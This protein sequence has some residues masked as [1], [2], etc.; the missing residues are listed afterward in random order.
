MYCDPV[1][2]TRFQSTPSG[3]KAT[4]S[5]NAACA[6]GLVSIHAFRGEGDLLLHRCIHPRQIVSIHAFRGEGDTRATAAVARTQEVSIHAFRGEGDECHCC[7]RIDRGDV[8]IHAFRGEGDRRVVRAVAGR[9]CFNP[10]LPGGR[11]RC[12]R[13]SVN[14]LDCFNPRL[15]GGRRRR[16]LRCFEE[17][18]GVSIHAFRGEGDAEVLQV[19]MTV[20]VSIHAFRGEGDNLS[21]SR[22]YDC[23]VSIHAFRG[24]GDY[25]PRVPIKRMLA[26]QSTPSGGK[27]TVYASVASGALSSFN[28]RLPGGRRRGRVEFWSLDNEFQS[29]P[30]GGKATRSHSCYT[31][32]YQRFNPRLPGGRRLRADLQTDAAGLGFNPRLPGGRRQQLGRNPPHDQRFNPRLPGGRRRIVET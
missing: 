20:D 22:L 11:R 21:Y 4:D 31:P 10:R 26:F 12:N 32:F 16:P 17:T 2:S 7:I 25:C 14:T 8:S 3:G 30:S 24:E 5:G 6:H 29:T 23:N 19:Q 27:A 13:I 18:S 28:P 15:P 1:G 9:A